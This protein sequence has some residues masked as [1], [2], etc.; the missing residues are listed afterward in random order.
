MGG[1]WLSVQAGQKVSETLSE[2]Q[3]KVKMVE[4]RYL[5]SQ[6]EALS[7]NLSMANK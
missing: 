2:N 3:T 4:I 1:L 7:S 6:C 5:P